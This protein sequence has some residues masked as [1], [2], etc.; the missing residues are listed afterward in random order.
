MYE[1]N[2]PR[3]Y[4]HAEKIICRGC[5]KPINIDL[6]GGGVAD[7]LWW[8][9]DVKGNWPMLSNLGNVGIYILICFMNVV[10]KD[11]WNKFSVA[12]NVQ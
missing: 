3:T 9:G 2:V 6:L 7:S 8:N 1:I 4:G 11:D 5:L 10:E 12:L